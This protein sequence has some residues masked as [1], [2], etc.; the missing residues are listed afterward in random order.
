MQQVAAAVI[1]ED[2]R[3]LLVRRAKGET[4]A[5]YW[6]LP[7]GKLED[8]ETL[9]QCLG[10]ELQEELAMAADVKQELMRTVYHYSHGS[11]EMIALRTERLS[12]FELTVHDACLWAA[13]DEVGQLEL[14]PAD[15]VLVHQ[16]A[17]HEGRF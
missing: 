5:G 17:V 11:F 8:G 12:E 7:G 3:L 16:L 1:I 9:Q 2:G 13:P 14:A 10:R 15:V 4:L 6:E